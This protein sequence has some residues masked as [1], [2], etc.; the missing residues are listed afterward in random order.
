MEGKEDRQLFIMSYFKLPNHDIDLT[1]P[2]FLLTSVLFKILLWDLLFLR[3]KS[4]EN[5]R[6]IF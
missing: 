1:K 5:L 6:M 4:V 3:V 2:R